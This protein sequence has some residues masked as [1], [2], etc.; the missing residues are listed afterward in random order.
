MAQIV[1]EHYINWSNT[2]EDSR[3]FDL[4][5]EF[6][7]LQAKIGEEIT[8][9]VRLQSKTNR[10]GMILAEISLPPGAD[11]NRASLEKAKSKGRFSSYDILPDKIVIYAWMGNLPLEFNFK[12]RPRF[13]RNAQTAPSIV[14]DYYNEEAKT[15]IAPFR[16]SVK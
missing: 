10:Y 1:S 14:Y 3:Y 11:V 4:K 6:N 13:E 7:S 12:F 16:F 5:I 15:T 8:C 9:Q 2:P